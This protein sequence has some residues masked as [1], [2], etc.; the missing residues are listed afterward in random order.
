MI[1]KNYSD[2]DK[3]FRQ[4][5]EAVEK[6]AKFYNVTEAPLV[7]E[8][9]PFV[10]PD[11]RHCRIPLETAKKMRKNIAWPSVQTAGAVVR[12]RTDSSRIWIRGKLDEYY[13][14]NNIC[15]S[16]GFDI[17]TGTGSEMRFCGQQVIIKPE[18][19]NFE[20]GLKLPHP[21]MQDVSIYLPISCSFFKMEI[22]VE[23][24]AKIKQPTPHRYKKP[25]VFY[26]SSITNIGSASRPALLYV[27]MIGRMLDVPI[28]NM[29]FSGSC[30]GEKCVAD[31]IAKL[32]PLAF[33][34]EYDSNAP[35]PEF[36]KNTH[37]AFFKHFR[38]HFPKLP[39]LMISS[40]YKDYSEE[41]AQ[42]RR[43]II[44]RTWLNAFEAG[45]RHVE[46]IDGETLLAGNSMREDCSA[47]CC[48]E[49]D[50]GARLMAERITDRLKRLINQ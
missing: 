1:A 41:V 47:D 50:I 28:I 46:F 32:D 35:D 16:A 22:G 24:G 9:M 26:G 42:I 31:E 36:L 4:K 44:A 40:P 43:A 2:I 27:S 21:K 20:L 23:S 30:F 13:V 17:Y 14:S 45:D 19:E 34:L 29:G 25:I 10:N 33:V 49:N 8:G 6:D 18:T 39:V 15:V 5:T 48:H 12:F 11:G 37:E 7:L 38:K 3:N